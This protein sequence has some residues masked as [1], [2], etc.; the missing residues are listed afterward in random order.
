MTPGDGIYSSLRKFGIPLFG[1][2]FDFLFKL[3]ILKGSKM[4]IIFL[5]D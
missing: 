5:K 1:I 3:E 2:I 4:I